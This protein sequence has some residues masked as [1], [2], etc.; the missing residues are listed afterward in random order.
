MRTT[1]SGIKAWLSLRD[2]RHPLFFAAVVAVLC[3]LAS[4]CGVVW[5]I[6]AAIAGT[7]VAWLAGLKQRIPLWLACGLLAVAVF[8]LRDTSRV[9]LE[10]LNS[11]HEEISASGRLLEDARGTERF[12]AARVKLASGQPDGVN[13]WWEGDG[14]PPVA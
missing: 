6:L 13:V 12:W 10:Q 4:H 1:S 9:P 5:G 8:F 11:S 7:G 3:V 2:S 14:A